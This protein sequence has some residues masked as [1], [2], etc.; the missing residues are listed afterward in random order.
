MILEMYLLQ[1]EQEHLWEELLEVY[2]VEEQYQEVHI[3]MRW[4]ILQ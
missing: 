2:L 3:K 4:I 1:E